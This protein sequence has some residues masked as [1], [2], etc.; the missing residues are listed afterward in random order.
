MRSEPGRRSDHDIAGHAGHV[1][2]LRAV[3]RGDVVRGCGGDTSIFAPYLRDGVNVRP[4][5]VWLARDD[6]IRM[7]ISGPPRL[8]SR[9]QQVLAIADAQ[10]VVFGNFAVFAQLRASGTHV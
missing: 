7:P 4:L 1:A 5:L 6:L 8:T 2:L 10:T 3:A 9:G